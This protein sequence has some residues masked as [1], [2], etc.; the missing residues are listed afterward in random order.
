MSENDSKQ[1][2]QHAWIWVLVVIVVFIFGIA[3][4]FIKDSNQ[5]V[6]SK[7]AVSAQEGQVQN[8]LDRRGSDVPELVGAVKGSQKQE[9]SVYGTIAKARTEYYNAKNKYSNSSSDKSKA[10]ALNTQ[11][12]AINAIVG[13]IKEAYP[14]LDSNSRMGDLMSNIEGSNNRV[15]VERMTLQHKTE[16]YDNKVQLFPSSIVASMTN[17]HT[18]PYYKASQSEQK[19]PKVNF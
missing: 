1:W 8:V 15:A 7:Q 11:N 16:S 18:I 2:Y 5:L 12:G 19:A 14:H 6:I 9:K 3:S 13:S 10:Q 4:W 17:H